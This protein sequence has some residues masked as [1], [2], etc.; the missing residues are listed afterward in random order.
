M[1]DKKY[2]YEFDP[3]GGLAANRV[4]PESHTITPANGSDFDV[5]IP[6]FAPFFRK[7]MVVKHITSG[8]T[9]VEGI[10]FDLGY[11]F[12]AASKQTATPIYGAIVI[13]D[14]T[15]S[16][17][18]TVEYQTLGGEW[19]MDTQ[20]ILTLLQNVKTD[21]RTVRWEDVIDKP[22][23][24]PPVDHLHHSDDLVGMDDVTKG[25]EAIRV[26][27]GDSAGKALSALLEH[28]RDHANPHEVSLAQLG[29]DSLG[30]LSESTTADVDAGT[31][32]L[33]FISA[34]R[35]QYFL[36]SK[37][38]PAINTHANNK[39]NPHGVTKAQVGLDLVEN[40]RMATLGE[41]L[42]GTLTSR[43]MSPQLVAAI[44][45]DRIQAALSGN[46]DVPT[47]D[48]IGL[49]NVQNYG[50][51]NFEQAI[52]GTAENLYMSPLRVAQHV[53]NAVAAVMQQHLDAD[54]P[55][56]ITATTVGLSNVRNFGIATAAE[57]AGGTAT[58][59]YTTVAGVTTMMT[60]FY[61]AGPAGQLSAHL[62]DKTNP[63]GV[64][65][66]QVGLGNVQNYGL[67]TDATF[68]DTNNTAYLTPGVLLRNLW[69]K[70]NDRTVEAS[71]LG[72]VP[73]VNG[74]PQYGG[75]RYG[76]IVSRKIGF[77]TNATEMALL[78][79]A[80][81][82]F[83]R[84]FNTWRRIS[85]K[86]SLVSPALPAETQA[87]EYD[88][89]KNAIVC[90]VNSD[91]LVGFVSPE[92]YS[93]YVFEVRLSSVDG[94]DDTIGIILGCVVENGLTYTLIASRNCGG[95]TPNFIS[96]APKLFSVAINA[97]STA[98]LSTVVASG[99]Y[100]L[101]WGDGVVDDTRTTNP[102]SKGWGNWP[103][104][105]KIRAVREGDKITVT[106]TD[107][108]SDT[109]VPAATIVIDLQSSDELRRFASKSAIGYMAQSQNS[110]T[111]KTIT[112]PDAKSPIY[113][114]TTNQL[115]IFDGNAWGVSD[116]GGG[117]KLT[118][119]QLYHTPMTGKTHFVDTETDI[120]LV[121][122]LNPTAKVATA[123][124][125][126]VTL[127]GDGTTNNPLTAT[128]TGN[129]DKSVNSTQ[130]VTANN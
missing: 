60:A 75:F 67:A 92:S 128:F 68:A 5:I 38:Q 40:Y 99:N 72:D 9:L 88:A 116:G 51:A 35:L 2:L 53:A 120:F 61:N 114:L 14:R 28:L 34:R 18:L 58:D 76:R 84:V 81:E 59:K 119:G 74:D 64:N 29:L 115:L 15:L 83:G 69:S 112:R 107:L 82:D 65:K 109:Y 33:R 113:D 86:G 125:L 129:T 13:T 11:K 102:G 54:N 123:N 105:C 127:S 21:P 52:A 48:S 126:S 77:A 27:V 47:K 93:D 32:N 90:K 6:S 46:V 80:D 89:T 103:T 57:L 25:I 17:Q 95:S 4:P 1:F 122:D 23:T 130:D 37:V 110:S 118:P 56:K 78:K 87:W 73:L 42:E 97:R 19:V 71:Q 31:D 30:G 43:Y 96:G 117:V 63:H 55:H 94:D 111:W 85:I 36:T 98:A 108:G 79:A 44:V 124:S 121:A 106:T 10:H 66:T 24:F 12:E 26:A 39:N 91:S 45:T 16:G 7:G 49:G 100:G 20:E 101:K 3:S 8:Q 104:G 22:I 62:A 41:A 70:L 50:M